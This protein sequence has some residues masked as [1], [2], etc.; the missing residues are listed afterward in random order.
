MCVLCAVAVTESRPGTS[1]ASARHI[2]RVMD[3][4]DWDRDTDLASRSR[5]FFSG[6]MGVASLNS[7][8]RGLLGRARG[9]LPREH[10]GEGPGPSL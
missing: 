8:Q 7:P 4:K 1:G 9:A 3:R 10:T 2:Q 6:C 5:G